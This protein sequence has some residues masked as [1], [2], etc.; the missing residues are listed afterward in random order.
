MAEAVTV[1]ATVAEATAVAVMGGRDVKAGRADLVVQEDHAV[2]SANIF[3]R[4]KSA[5]FAWRR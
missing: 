2:G 1:V 3:A 4:R 5:N